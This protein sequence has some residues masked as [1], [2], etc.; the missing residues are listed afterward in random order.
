LVL[1]LWDKLRP[2]IEA[3]EA[4]TEAAEDLAQRPDDD[5]ARSAFE[6][7]LEKLLRGDP[8]L[9][10]ELKGMLEKAKRDGVI[11]GDGAV[12]IVGDVRADRGGVASGGNINI[13]EGGLRTGWKGGDEEAGADKK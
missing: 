10:G 13:Q 4:S 9:Q 3:K 8:A 1:K 2:K 11:A 6:L 7:Q 12:V 5:R